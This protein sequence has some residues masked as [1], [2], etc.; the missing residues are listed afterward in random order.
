MALKKASIKKYIKLFIKPILYFL[1][2]MVSFRKRALLKQNKQF[3]DLYKAQR[4]FLLLTGAS[5]DDIDLSALRDEQTMTLNL[6]GLHKRV[7]DIDL[8]MYFMPLSAKK[9]NKTRSFET[10]YV[11]PVYAK[12]RDRDYL[13]NYQYVIKNNPERAKNIFELADKSLSKGSIVFS[14][15]TN[16][17]YF[18]KYS[19]FED[20]QMIFYS[21]KDIQTDLKSAK[22][23]LDIDLDLTKRF[24]ASSNTMINCILLLIYLGFTEIYLCGAGY[25]FDSKYEFHFYDSYLVPKGKGLKE[26]E[27]LGREIELAY[28]TANNTSI[29][30]HGLKEEYDHYR[31]I[32]VS[33]YEQIDES[34]LIHAN[35]NDY[36]N[37]K[38]VKIFNIIP[39]NFQSPVYEKIS[40]EKVKKKLDKV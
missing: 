37:S 8:K 14:E 27:R 6:L 1:D 19:L 5:I 22:D 35:T 39:D 21:F 10:D 32:Y 31:V 30:Y 7:K 2:D 40:W 11:K 34:H 24:P 18:S 29:R 38:G 20:K 13:M 23:Y 3:K 33:N 26:A 12:Y 36:A 15:T 4:C 25:T 28:N 16:I 17:K 9:I